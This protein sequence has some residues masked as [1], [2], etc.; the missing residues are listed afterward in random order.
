[1]ISGTW[2]GKV[3][4]REISLALVC[5][6]YQSEQEKTNKT[7]WI[8]ELHWFESRKFVFFF[9]LFC[10]VWGVGWG[11]GMVCFVSFSRGYTRFPDIICKERCIL[12]I[13]V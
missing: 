1:M 11:E 5:P 12:Y 3:P 9:V 4:Q 13:S 7:W 2:K 8:I 10:F 6:S